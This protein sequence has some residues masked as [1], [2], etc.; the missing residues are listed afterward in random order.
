MKKTILILLALSLCIFAQHPAYDT[1]YHTVD[2]VITEITAL[3]DTYSTYCHL[4]SLGH[5]GV[6]SITI[7]GLKIS[8]NPSVNE[9][10]TVVE[11]H[12]GQHADEPNGVEVCMWMIREILHRIDSGDTQALQWWENL[13]IWIIPQMNPDGRVMC[14]DSGYVEWRK[15]KR[16]ND[17]DG[18]YEAYTDGVD[19]NRNWDFR[20]DEYTPSDLDN[21]KGPYPF[22]EQCVIVMKE[23][24]EKHRPITILDY[25]SPDSCGGNKLWICW[26][27]DDGPYEGTYGPDAINCW[28]DI[29]D[30]L[31]YATLDEEGNYYEGLAS[32]NDKP[33]LQTWTYYELGS[34]SIVMEITNQ[35]FWEGEIIDTISQRVGRGSFYLLDRALKEMIVTHVVDTAGNPILDAVVEIDELHHEH[36]PPRTVDPVHGTNRRYVAPGFYKVYVDAPDY[37]PDTV[38]DVMVNYDEIAELEVVLEFD[39]TSISESKRPDKF[40]FKIAPNPFNSTVYI[41]FE[42]LSG[43]TDLE[44]FDIS[45]RHVADLSSNLNESHSA[46]GLAWTPDSDLGSGIYLIR[47]TT[48]NESISKRVVY[49]K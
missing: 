13:E 35:C 7:W 9:D 46:I 40:D 23:F 44:I 18:I 11:F 47:A 1:R 43:L 3:A 16:D 39:P 10:E 36:F 26:W 49:L 6:D 38:S 25:H 4:E 12:G 22:S 45:G 33:K 5:S 42:N 29:R 28:L 8:D 37:F 19:P 14:L 32:Y 31:R 2:E 27:F 17:G 15:T 41:E 21:T 24:F 48:K 20:W 30:E 34:C